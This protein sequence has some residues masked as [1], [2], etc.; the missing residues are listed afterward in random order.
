MCVIVLRCCLAILF[1]VSV[2]VAHLLHLVLCLVVVLNWC[3]FFICGV[4]VVVH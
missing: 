1:G 3:V 2:C 4:R